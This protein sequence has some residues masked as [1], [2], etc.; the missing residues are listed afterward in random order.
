MLF[1]FQAE[2]GIRD[3][4][5]TG[6]QTCALPISSRRRHT[7]LVSD[8]SSD[9]CSSD[10]IGVNG[11][12]ILHRQVWVDPQTEDP[13]DIP[14]D[15][16]KQ[17]DEEDDFYG[18]G[19]MQVLGPANEIRA[20]TLGGMLEHQDRFLNRKVFVPITSTYQAKSAQ[21][22]TATHIPINAGGEPKYE[23]IPHFPQAPTQMFQLTSAQVGHWSGLETPVTGESD[24][25]NKSRLPSRT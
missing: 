17:M 7:R 23:E 21:A 1:C 13:M 2:D 25:P 5:V 11:D 12:T 15:Q 22:M 24:P 9:V 3:W 16:C 4:S 8:W 19:M 10:L 6:V 18:R 14:L 20:S